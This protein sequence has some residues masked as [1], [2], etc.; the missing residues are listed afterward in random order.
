M[1]CSRG[2]DPWP[3]CRGSG[4]IKAPTTCQ[5]VVVVGEDSAMSLWKRRTQMTTFTF[6]NLG[7]R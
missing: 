4:T 2:P 6:R 7:Q 5:A 1:T 3:R